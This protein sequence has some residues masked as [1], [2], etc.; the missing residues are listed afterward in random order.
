MKFKAKCAG[1][2]M[3]VTVQDGTVAIP[4]EDRRALER[5]DAL[6]ALASEQPV[7]KTFLDALDQTQAALSAGVISEAHVQGALAT[8][9]TG[10]GPSGGPLAQYSNLPAARAAR[11]ADPR[12]PVTELMG[13]ADTIDRSVQESLRGNPSCT[14]EVLIRSLRAGPELARTGNWCRLNLDH[15]AVDESVLLAC[16]ETDGARVEQI[17]M[18]PNVTA[19]VQRAVVAQHPE[20]AHEADLV[21][22]GELL[23]LTATN[24]GDVDLRALL[25][26]PDADATHRR[27]V[28]EWAFANAPRDAA[29]I[30]TDPDM[31]E[32]LAALDDPD[33]RHIVVGRRETPPEQI[34][35][36]I[37]SAQADAKRY[38]PSMPQDDCVDDQRAYVDGLICAAASNPSVPAEH[39]ERFL[40]SPDPRVRCAAAG[41]PSVPESKANAVLA[42]IT[43]NTRNDDLLLAVL[44]NERTSHATLALA[45]KRGSGSV[46]LQF[47]SHPKV[48]RSE[49]E[50]V[51]RLQALAA[52]TSEDLHAFVSHERFPLKALD[53]LFRRLDWE[54]NWEIRILSSLAAKRA[55]G[56]DAEAIIR[57]LR[58]WGTRDTV[59]PH[60][61]QE[62]L[63]QNELTTRSFATLLEG[64][65]FVD[66]ERTTAILGH[67]SFPD[68]LCDEVI[69]SFDPALVPVPFRNVHRHWDARRQAIID[70]RIANEW[71]LPGFVE[72]LVRAGAC[73]SDLYTPYITTTVDDE[74]SY[75]LQLAIAET[76][77]LSAQQLSTL[78]RH[79]RPAV[80]DAAAG[81]L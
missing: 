73:P 8:L 71:A 30:T 57:F 78:M 72:L 3:T 34:A 60:I 62:L 64:G 70:E 38:Y 21:S 28:L 61:L 80:R 44:G 9:R 46:K 47:A 10:H 2:S 35:A 27:V 81:R 54:E 16:L 69:Q 11:A 53:K 65:V 63:D 40:R 75:H 67:P 14:A 20:R 25:E 42:G 49:A 23:A 26:R 52:R 6:R 41:N 56:P 1:R 59:Y 66:H 4:D 51:L 29:L 55:S 12:T 32:Q 76:A 79:R 58:R 74:P 33:V 15:P 39:L 22:I 77:P 24:L 37:E 18:H 43:K 7:G 19:D 31:L 13:L 50:K 36:L 17:L 5:E 68:E 48:R 45:A